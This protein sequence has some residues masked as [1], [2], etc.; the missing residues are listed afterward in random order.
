MTDRIRNQAPRQG[1]SLAGSALLIALALALWI[2]ASP[3]PAEGQNVDHLYGQAGAAMEAGRYQDAASLYRQAGQLRPND[4]EP[5]I[6]LGYALIRM[7]QLED[8]IATLDRALA[9][10]P[11]SSQAHTN[12]GFALW[13]Y[14][15]R[16]KAVTSYTI[17][18]R[19]D[20]TNAMAFYNLGNSYSAMG[21]PAEAIGPITKAIELQPDFV[22]AFIN[23]GSVRIALGDPGGAVAPLRRAVSLAQG[24]PLAHYNLGLALGRTGDMTAAAREHEWLQAESPELASQLH[25]HLGDALLRARRIDEALQPPAPTAQPETDPSVTLL[26]Q[27]AGEGQQGWDAAGAEDAIVGLWYG[28]FTHQDGPTPMG[29]ANLRITKTGPGVYQLQVASGWIKADD[30]EAT[31]LFSGCVLRFERRAQDMRGDLIFHYSGDSG[32]FYQN[33]SPRPVRIT[34]QPGYARTWVRASIAEARTELNGLIRVEDGG[35]EPTTGE[36]PETSK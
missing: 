3:R 16:Q 18:T 27:S 23:L 36:F 10:N 22:D 1:S 25:N 13:Q 5:L 34:L 11:N 30:D 31:P 7:G 14:G 15:D 6:G 19:L 35:Q 28:K 32:F 33:G 29:E 4:A 9:I 21:S 12:M 17:A 24:R 2:L 26:G 20:P 8:A